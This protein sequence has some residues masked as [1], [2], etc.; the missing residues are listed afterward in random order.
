[1]TDW[2]NGIP[3]KR[4]RRPKPKPPDDDLDEPDADDGLACVVW[5]PIRCPACRSTH[6]RNYRTNGRVRYHRCQDC[7]TRFKSYELAEDEPASGI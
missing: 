7:E 6:Q 3:R 5:R 4:R 2:L 1:M